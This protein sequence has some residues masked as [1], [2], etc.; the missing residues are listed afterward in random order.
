MLT[1][2]NAATN[3][4]FDGNS[5]LAGA[6]TTV[7]DRIGEKLLALAPINGAMTY[8]NV[9]VNGRT[10]MGMLSAVAN[11]HAAFVAGKQ[12][13]L[14][15]LEGVNTANAGYDGPGIV[16][17]CKNYVAA[18]KATHPGWRIFILIAPAFKDDANRPISPGNTAIDYYNDYVRSNYKRLGVEGFVETR[19]A[20]GPLAYVPPYVYTESTFVKSGHYQDDLHLNG[21]GNAIV[22]QYIAD[23]LPSIPEVAPRS[24]RG[25]ARILIGG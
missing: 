10:F 22:A 20:G 25:S 13:L 1:W 14:F 9:A 21:A 16:T 5:L 8:T 7:P 24:N 15:I 17:H 12:N 2:T 18:V 6:A 19:P 23:M 4:V 3:L 11:V